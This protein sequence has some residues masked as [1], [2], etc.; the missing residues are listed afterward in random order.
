MKTLK[1][2]ESHSKGKFKCRGAD[3]E[4]QVH[5]DEEVSLW[6]Q[7]AK[8]LCAGILSY[9]LKLDVYKAIDSVVARLSEFLHGRMQTWLL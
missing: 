1:N 5:Q 3:A 8:M 4:M 7:D 6:A 2:K 9:G